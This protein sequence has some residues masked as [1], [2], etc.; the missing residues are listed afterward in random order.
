[1]KKDIYRIVEV[2]KSTLTKNTNGIVD[3]IPE[4]EWETYYKIEI[5]ISELWGS[6]KY[7]KYCAIGRSIEHCERIIEF[8]KTEDTEIVIKET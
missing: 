7:W 5:L 6:Y 2:K 8:Y 1:M 4:I 3:F